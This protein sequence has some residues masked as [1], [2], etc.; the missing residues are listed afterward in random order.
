MWDVYRLSAGGGFSVRRIVALFLAVLL[1]A[2]FVAI[3]NSPITRADGATWDGD[4]IK[5]GGKTYT[6]LTPAPTLPGISPTNN[7]IYVSGTGSDVSV[8][9]LKENADK[10]QAITDAQTGEF[11]KDSNGNYSTKPGT[12]PPSP[13]SIAASATGTA[14]GT[15]GS[16]SSCAIQG[17]GWLVCPITGFLAGMMDVI[18]DLLKSFF[19]VNTIVDDQDSAIYRVWDVMRGLANLCFIV[20]FLVIIYSQ[21]TSYGINNYEIKKMIPKLII[22]AVLVNVSY[23]IC[24]I[25]VD[26][27]NIL[28]NSLQQVF[29]DM[30]GNII[31]SE[32]DANTTATSWKS[33]TAFI[34]S[35]GGLAA[36]G[37]T[38]GGIAL[39]AGASVLSLLPMLVS[40]LLGVFVSAVIALLVLAVRQAL[41]VILVAIA[42]LA[43]VAMLLPGTE[44]WFDK[45]KDIMITMLVLFPMFAVVFGGSQ[46]AGSLIIQSADSINMILVGMFAQIAPLVIT[47]LLIK[48]SGSVLG[49]VAGIMNNR[50]K[51]F[52]DSTRNKLQEQ[53]ERRRHR[54]LAE[55]HMGMANGERGM[56]GSMK[57]WAARRENGRHTKEHDD[58]AYKSFSKAHADTHWKERLF[59][60]DNNGSQ[61]VITPS[62]RRRRQLASVRDAYAST[63]ASQSRSEVLDA[64]DKKHKEEAKTVNTG[65]YATNGVYADHHGHTMSV[66]QAAQQAALDNS[67]E[68]QA[69]NSAT[70]MANNE[71]A[72][73]L[74]D[75]TAAGQALR[76]RAGGIDT[77]FGQV[78]A[79]AQADQT[80]ADDRS[81]GM[82][83]IELMINLQNPSEEDKFALAKGVGVKGIEIN[84]EV[85]ET[86]TKMI[87]GGGNVKLINDLAEYVDL[88][89]GSDEFVRTAFV[90]ALKA[91]AAKP[92][93][94]S[95]T[96]LN[97]LGQGSVPEFKGT[98]NNSDGIADALM[99]ALESNKFDAKGLTSEDPDTLVRLEKVMRL[100]WRG[101]TPAVQESLKKAFTRIVEDPQYG[102]AVGNRKEALL[103]IGKNA[104]VDSTTLGK[105]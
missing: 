104:G 99:A 64:I 51:G 9:A 96:L 53:D 28:G 24:A 102:G 7:Q 12:D 36:A 81:N 60:D 34:L 62:G 80:R 79:L 10:S 68:N 43:F 65:F 22:A 3:A 86:A 103:K 101:Q 14:N 8:I 92:K 30:R 33:V 55:G 87:A 69:A 39:A 41:I 78:R 66:S 46:L 83:N 89:A 4:N 52:I 94:Y 38:T 2:L 71:I 31:G 54:R 45:W 105:L 48:L 17:I 25:A 16:T 37:L 70:R 77:Q 72:R 63:Y 32:T 61:N 5:Y 13:V 57:R 93:H 44:K 21:I 42:P 49:R 18:F 15:A 29:I 40:F 73:Q 91:N 67:V 50:Q 26:A 20:V 27:S 75:K 35:G 97:R 90:D 19:E 47:P 76:V 1:S 100:D 98:N 59:E 56:G 6:K 84:R 58:E 85:I 82:K 11:V 88:S 23:Y 95:A 74:A